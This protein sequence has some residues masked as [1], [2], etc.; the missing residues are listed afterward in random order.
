MRGSVSVSLRPLVDITLIARDGHRETAPVIVDSGFNGEV[1]LPRA[2]MERL[3]WRLLGGL[4]FRMAD[5]RFV[6]LD[7]YKGQSDWEGQAR[8]VMALATRETALLDMSLLSP[9]RII[10]DGVVGGAV[11]IERL[12]Q[13]P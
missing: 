1:G 8:H 7:V 2:L 5:D 11:I 4:P 13:N 3:G 10:I 9:C 6:L 12:T